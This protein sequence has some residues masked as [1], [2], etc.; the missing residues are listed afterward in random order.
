MQYE[1]L[2]IGFGVA[3]LIFLLIGIKL[4]LNLRRLIEWLIGTIALVCLLMTAFLGFCIIDIRTYT[5]M[6]HEKPIATVSFDKIDEQKY[7]MRLVND[8]G[9]EL[10]Y[11]IEGDAWRLNANVLVWSQR[12]AS[13]GMQPGYRLNSL[14]GKYYALDQQRSRE[15]TTAQIAVS[16]YLDV[17][18][19]VSDNMSEDSMVYAR[20]AQ[21]SSQP[22]ADGAL[23]EVVVNGSKLTANPLND[24]ARAA[25]EQW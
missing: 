2:A 8:K 16:Q 12:L 11:T 25:A 3:G 4:F 10:R 1:G 7:E 23:Y 9:L 22:M 6:V 24:A 21:V 13:M 15:P 19:L 18:Q 17:W 14:S 20:T 5:P